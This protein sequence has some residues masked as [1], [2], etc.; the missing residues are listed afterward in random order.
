MEIFSDDGALWQLVV[1]AL[2][3]MC[4]AVAVYALVEYYPTIV[5]HPTQQTLSSKEASQCA[6]KQCASKQCAL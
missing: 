5:V 1:N 4:P 2:V 3:E 6:T